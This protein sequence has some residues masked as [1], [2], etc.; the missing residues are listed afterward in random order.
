MKNLL[1]ILVS[2]KILSVSE[3]AAAK[4]VLILDFHN[5]DRDGSLTYLEESLTAS[6]RTY[7][8]EKY[9]FFEPDVVDVRKRADAD[10]FIFPDD[11]HNKNVALHLGLAM[12]QDIVLSGAFKRK[13]ESSGRNLIIVDIMLLNVEKRT[14]VKQFVSELYIDSNIFKSIEL[15]S[16]RVVK[17]SQ[18]ILPNKSEFEFDIH[19]PLSQNQLALFS[20]YNLNSLFPALQKN[21]TIEN[22][23]RVVVADL[24][25]PFLS[26]EFRRDRFFKLARLIGYGRLDGQFFLSD[27][28]IQDSANRAKIQ[29]LGFSAELGLGYNLFRYKKLNL[30]F[31]GGVGFAYAKVSLDLQDTGQPDTV[32]G[33]IFGP[34]A[35][36][37]LRAAF[38]ISPSTSF[39]WGVSYQAL[40]LQQ[41][42]AGNLLT[43]IGVGFRL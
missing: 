20:G 22:K 17:E 15:V 24:G 1:W 14:L 19:S 13:I 29:G 2:V 37:G 10:Y 42:L 28:A 41:S 31:L 16:R 12:G 27:L 6:V 4:R 32:T 33:S 40:F 18:E 30:Y 38:Q 34:T 26:L 8:H 21:A 39:E 36:T 5:T 43:S 35:S 23:S 25:G 3:L 11:L 9:E 7:L